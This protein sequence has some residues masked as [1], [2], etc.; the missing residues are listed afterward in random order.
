M[1]IEASRAS[2]ARNTGCASTAA[3]P[4]ADR[5][6][7]RL[8]GQV[9]F[10]Q[11]AAGTVLA[12]TAGQLWQIALILFV[13]QRF[14]SPALAGFATFVAIVPGLVVSPLAGALLDRYGCLRLIRVDLSVA[15]LALVLLAALSLASALTPATLLVIVAL[16][17][18][19][20]PLTISGTR[21]LFPRAVPRELWD[22]ANGVDSGSM[23]LAMVV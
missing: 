7:R 10:P 18:L 22:R 11:L 23:A 3:A 14:H 21:T 17:S 4:V 2:K 6:Y 5:T 9:S 15:A 16:S 19:T 12:R 8:F 1:S 20:S 13:L